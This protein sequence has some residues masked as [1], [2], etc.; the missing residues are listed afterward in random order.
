MFLGIL[1][2]VVGILILA[3]NLGWSNFLAQYWPIVL[4]I[5]GIKMMLDEYAK[6]RERAKKSE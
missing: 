6:K 5:F 2:V 4:V 3:Q 1:L